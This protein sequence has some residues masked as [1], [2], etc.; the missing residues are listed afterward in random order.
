M[1][2]IR[3]LVFCCACLFLLGCN[4]KS[5][6]D[7][8]LPSLI[9]MQN[10]WLDNSVMLY[11]NGDRVTQ[12][13]ASLLIK[14]ANSIVSRGPY[15][16]T[17]KDITPPSGD[18]H[19]YMS[20]GPYWW[21]NP[22]TPDGLPWVKRDGETNPSSE[23]GGTDKPVLN[24]M[25]TDVTTMAL[26]YTYTR[27]EKYA[28]QGAALLNAWFVASKTR[29]NPHL[30]FGQAV[31]GVSAGRVY[32]VIETRW[33]ARLTDDITLLSSSDALT[34]DTVKNIKAWFSDYLAW[35]TQSDIGKGACDAYNNHGS[36]CEAQTA[37]IAY[38]VGNK[39]L[40]KKYVKRLFETRMAKQFEPN[41]AQP[42]E[43][44][45]TRPLHYS[46]FNLEAYFIGARVG[47][48]LGLNYWDYTAKNG[49]SIKQAI[50]FILPAIYNND[51]WAD[52][53][54]SPK[55]RVA[56]L[57]YFLQYGHEKY[58]RK[59]D[60]KKYQKAMQDLYPF[61]AKENRNEMFQCFL[62]MPQPE[63]YSLATLNQIDPDR[64]KSHYRCYY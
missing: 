6:P 60:D 30:N 13:S 63:G 56:R 43:L 54:Y 33:L 19:D 48:A 9:I 41:G 29:M 17:S 15:S 50:D 58:G 39:K 46:V 37:A 53:A 38:F 45:R 64:V 47:D 62:Q 35:L 7:Q 44:K 18:K 49:A 20:V 3:L 59:N 32:G 23:K 55:M 2:F 12:E 51:Y 14:K 16:V 42:D 27:N 26:A 57:Y 24:N 34:H 28:L 36:Y 10:T 4:P 52:N 11:K 22:D 8:R 61:A 40:A 21:P 5:E 25:L 1:S 31:P